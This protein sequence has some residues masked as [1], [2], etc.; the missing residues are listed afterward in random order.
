LNGD[1]LSADFAAG[2]DGVDYALGGSAKFIV[3]GTPG[4]DD[5]PTRYEVAISNDGSQ[6][7][8][9]RFTLKSTGP[10]FNSDNINI[11]TEKTPASATATGTK[12]QI[13]WDASYI[14]VCIAT[15]VWKR[16]AIVTWP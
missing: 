13:C 14:Y 15:D 6:T 16:A 5:M 10:I 1:T 2:Y 4:A 12:G 8:T 11:A 7:P 3:D 9:T